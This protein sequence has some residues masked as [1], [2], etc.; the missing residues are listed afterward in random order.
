MTFARIAAFSLFGLAT[1]S[2]AESRWEQRLADDG[3]RLELTRDGLSAVATLAQSQLLSEGQEV[4]IGDIDKSLL[5]VG[6]HL[7]GLKV[8]F[9]AESIALVPIEGALDLKVGLR[10]ITLSVDSFQ[11]ERRVLGAALQK[12]CY[13]TDFFIAEQGAVYFQSKLGAEVDNR[14]ISLSERDTSFR[15]SADNYRVRGPGS[16]DGRLTGPVTRLL[17]RTVLKAARPAIEALVKRQVRELLPTLAAELT[18]QSNLSL[19]LDVAN[20]PPL[21]P[22]VV[23]LAAYPHGLTITPDGLSI[24]VGASI[25]GEDAPRFARVEQPRADARRFGSLGVN[26]LLLT[27]AIK[28][29]FPDGTSWIEVDASTLPELKGLLDLE[30]LKILWPDLQSVPTEEP[31]ARLKARVVTA[32]ELGADASTNALTAHIPQVELMFLV[33]TGGEWRDYSL[34]KLDIKT[35]VTPTLADGKLSISLLPGSTIGVEG[36]WVDGYE[37]T[38]TYFDQETADFLMTTLI[39]V[40]MRRG[41]L[42]SVDLPQV[43]V[44]GRPLAIGSVGVE[45]PFISVGIYDAAP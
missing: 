35:G 19:S 26:P 13:D 33:K 22:R 9:K 42:V 6:L 38:N 7:R 15:V 11:V 44:L 12:T 37:P 36:A 30:S 1:F 43:D 18:A 23:T 25:T 10:G 3:L 4:E 41:A 34:L 29:V 16:C 2:S 31:F 24:V 14:Q 20:F 27:E 21:P 5:G 17:L 8:A 32:P 28:A 45:T 39:D 40:A